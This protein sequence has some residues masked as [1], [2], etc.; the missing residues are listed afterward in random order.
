[1]PVVMIWM[2]EGRTSEQKEKLVKGITRVFEDI[3]TKAD[4]VQIVINDVSKNNWGVRG[5]LA[6]KLT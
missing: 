2:W 1:M 6:S 4:T 3:G 5:E